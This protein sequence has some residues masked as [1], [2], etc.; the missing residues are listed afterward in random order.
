MTRDSRP[1]SSMPFF[2]V[3]LPGA[4]L[5]RQQAALQPVGE[6]GDHALQM[7]QL[8]VELLAQ[9]GQFLGVAQLLGVDFLVDR[10]G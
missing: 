10:R 9:P 4:G 5:L 8:L 1:A 2:E 6:L 7:L 3:E